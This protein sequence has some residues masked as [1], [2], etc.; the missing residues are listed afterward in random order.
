MELALHSIFDP[1][2]VSAAHPRTVVSVHAQVIHDDGALLP[3]L[4]N[5]VSL[6]LVDAGVPIDGIVCG[7]SCGL[8]T[9]G[10]DGGAAVPA[11][12]APGS[13][14]LALDLLPSE[15]AQCAVAGAYAF[16]GAGGGPSAGPVFVRQ[17][18]CGTW[19]Q[20]RALLAEA[21][22]ACHTLQAFL[23]LAIQRK[24]A[25]DSVSFGPEVAAVR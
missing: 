9:G 20:T 7:V 8:T 11:T 14:G 10:G 3:A 22:R 1:V 15:E 4:I 18:G 5:C 2:I 24:L 21:E 16:K 6:S 17:S 19:E 12:V 25:R 23:R 13:G